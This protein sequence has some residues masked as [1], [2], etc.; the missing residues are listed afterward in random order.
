M[1]EKLGKNLQMVYHPSNMGKI[2]LTIAPQN[3][4][5]IYAAIELDR[6]TGGV[7]KA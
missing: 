5:I 6:R 2:G 3:T 4:N 7:Y 1:E